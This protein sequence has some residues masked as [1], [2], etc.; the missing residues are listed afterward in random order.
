[1]GK[2]VDAA[3]ALEQA[4]NY[5]KATSPIYNGPDK[6]KLVRDLNNYNTRPTVPHSSPNPFEAATKFLT[7][8]K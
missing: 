3:T 2:K 7:G 6:G 5:A 4:G 1:M 8:K